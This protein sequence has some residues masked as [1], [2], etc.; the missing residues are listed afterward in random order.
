MLDRARSDL[1][2]RVSDRGGRRT[3]ASPSAPAVSLRTALVVTHRW[4]ALTLGIALLAVVISGVVLLY[5]QEI[6]RV[7]HP[8]LHH[9]TASA[10]RSPTPRRSPSFA[11]MRPTSRPTD[12]VDSHGVYLIYDD[13]GTK[14]AYV[15]PGRA[16]C[17]ASTTRPMA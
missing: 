15:D 3:A 5:E 1:C 8:G 6:D 2:R 12:V 13:E 14:Q 10:G 4:L 7:V 11:A 17:S 9:A 16:G